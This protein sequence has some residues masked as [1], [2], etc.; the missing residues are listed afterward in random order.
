MQVST[1]VAECARNPND[2]IKRGF[3]LGQTAEIEGQRDSPVDQ[4][5]NAEGQVVFGHR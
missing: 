4:N 5:A 2:L 1:P 3:G